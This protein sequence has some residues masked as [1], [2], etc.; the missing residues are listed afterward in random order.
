M[1]DD[2]VIWTLMAAKAWCVFQEL[3]API[4]LPQQRELPVALV[5]QVSVKIEQ[6]VW[7]RFNSNND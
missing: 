7:V 3:S 2:S 5:H 1:K 6:N 4:M